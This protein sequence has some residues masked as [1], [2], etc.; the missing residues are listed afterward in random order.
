[1]RILIVGA[2]DV[3][4]QLGRR[5]SRDQH[6]ITLVEANPA[7][8][9]RAAEQ[10][11]ALVIEGSGD[12]YQVLL[13]AGLRNA[14]VVAAVTD[15]DNT[16]LLVCR[17]AKANGVEVTIARARNPDF[18][19]PEYPL[20]LADLGAD[21]IIHPERE[22]GMAILRLLQ[23][24]SATHVI[25]LE[26]GRIEV[27]GLIL[28]ADSP[29]IGPTLTELGE[30]Y[31]Y[32][33][34]QIVAIE[35]NHETII[36]KGTDR[37]LSGDLLF[38]VCAPEYAR[39]FFGLAGKRK[40]PRMDNIMLMGGGMIAQFLAQELAGVANIKIIESDLAR[41]ERLSE[42]LAHALVIHGD[43]TD[44]ELLQSEDLDQMDAFVAVTGDDENNIIATLLAHQNQVPRPVALV[45]RVAYLPIL[46][47]IGLNAVIS[48]QMLTVN[49]VQQFI[50]HRQVAAIASLPGIEGQMIE[51]IARARSRIVQRPLRDVKFPH[52]AVVGAVLR[53]GILIIPDGDTMIQPGDR[54]VVFALPSAMNELDRLFA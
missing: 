34:V 35:R 2:G 1:M 25:D 7:K 4:F 49:A 22:A 19:K 30:R 5:L 48:K 36:P 18:T 52:G 33:P 40:K 43:G 50:Q 20:T 51:F 26:N 9:R 37:L 27:L 24:S 45:N 3:G 54:T 21:H 42:Q 31:N 23:E 15:S 53:S 11:D 10:L 13:Q 46:P 14:D 6:D 29:L 47:K 8:V 38:A 32:P 39:E 17:L 28:E 44:L 41:A 16:N 12:S